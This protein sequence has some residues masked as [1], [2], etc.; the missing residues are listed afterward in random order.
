MFTTSGTY[1]W[2][3]LTH[4][5]HNGQPSY[6]SDYEHFEVMTSTYPRGTLDSVDSLLAA[7]LYHENPDRNPLFSGVRVARFLVFCVEL[8][9]SFP[10]P[11]LLVIVLSVPLRFTVSDYPF[12]I[13]KLFL[14]LYSSLVKY[15][16]SG[17][18]CAVLA[19]VMQSHDQMII[20]S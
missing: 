3:F 5:F 12:G 10:I 13:F 7:T 18:C 9:R 1:P 8:C 4:I 11:F 2:S 19:I 17:M 6:G 15:E 20:I 16:L 14:I